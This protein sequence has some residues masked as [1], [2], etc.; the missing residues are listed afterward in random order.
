MT[1]PQAPNDPER[2]RA[3]KV[4]QEL[5]RK[6]FFSPEANRRARRFQIGLELIYVGL[7]GIAFYT[8][9]WIIGGVMVVF[10]L[11]HGRIRR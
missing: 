8:G 6:M 3:E 4:V 1:T 9:H 2:E 10:G 5:G 7:T 11:V